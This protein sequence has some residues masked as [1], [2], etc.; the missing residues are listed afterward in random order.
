MPLG[1]ART[2]PVHVSRSAHRSPYMIV[3]IAVTSA[4]PYGG[5]MAARSDVQRVAEVLVRPRAGY[6]ARLDRARAAIGG[7]SAE[8]AR[9]LGM[10]VNRVGDLSTDELGEL[11]D[12]TFPNRESTA[13]WRVARRLTHLPPGAADVR[14]ALS[15]L[16]Q[17]LP[18]LEVDRNPFVYA[19]KALCCLLLATSGVT[20]ER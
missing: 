3:V 12:E 16:T 11:Y 2:G 19:L 7:R 15:T 9:L 13:I 6:I 1:G 20:P 14:D 5:A 18:R 4:W 10:F 8:A 17:L